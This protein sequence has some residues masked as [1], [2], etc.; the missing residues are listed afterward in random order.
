MRGVQHPFYSVIKN[1]T[2]PYDRQS[3][4]NEIRSILGY[5]F[6]CGASSHLFVCGVSR[7]SFKAEWGKPTY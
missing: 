6:H 7:Q 3:P 5:C 1:V 2:S 4:Q